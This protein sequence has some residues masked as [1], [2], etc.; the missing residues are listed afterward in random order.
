[1]DNFLKDLSYG[2]RT[3]RKSPGFTI[4]ALITLA[5][6][7]GATTA[8]FSVVNA[9]LLRPLPYPGAEQLVVINSEM[10]NRKVKDFPIAPADVKDIREQVTSLDQVA[11]VTSFPQP[12]VEDN[13]DPQQ[14]KTEF[15]TA[16]FIPT[17]GVPL[18]LGR[19]FRDEEAL[20]IPPP[21]ANVANGTVPFPVIDVTVILTHEFWMSHFGGDPSV[22]GRTLNLGGSN[23]HV[24]GVLAPDFEVLLP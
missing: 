9:V 11:G 18:A 6:G 8:I 10:R 5:L 21:P 14:V 3:L 2:I 22:I 7:I 23:A 17:L 20:P 12:L 16:N 1:M 24:V 4:T 13:R 15:V 19:N